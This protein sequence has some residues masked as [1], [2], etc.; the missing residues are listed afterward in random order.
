M[1]LPPASILA[2]L[3]VQNVGGVSRCE[4]SLEDGFTVFTGESGAGKSSI[5][6]AIE[7][8]AGKRAQ[9]SLI[10]A[11]EE[12]AAVEA[13]FSTSPNLRLPGLEESQQP[14][15]GSF[16]AKRALSR[17]GRGRAIL[18]GTQVPVALYSSSVGRLVHI[19]SQFAQLELL[20]TGRQL[21]MTD[22][23]G[24]E[25]LRESLEKLREVFGRARVKEREL[26]EIADRRA[27]IERRYAN[28]AEVVPLAKKVDL[29]EGLEA[30]L[31]AEAAD[32]SRRLA[33]SA[34]AGQ[35]LDRL[36]G[37]LSERGL[38]DEA[39]GLCKV[40]LE[41]VPPE[42]EEIC[43]S[44]FKEGLR[45]L[46]ALSDE[47]RRQT[48]KLPSPEALSR[49]IE[50]TERRLGSLR[51]LRRMAG[52]K[53]EGELADW[54]REAGEGLA[55]L[56]KSYDRLETFTR[57]ARELRREASRLA[58]EI[59]AGRRRAAEALEKRV[60]ALFED[61]A[62][63]GIGFAIR[64]S[65]LPKLRRDGA[66]EV[67]FELFTDKRSG[68][69]D[70]IA[71]G[72]E[73]SRLLLALQLSLPDEWL[74]PTLVFDEVE[75]GLGGRAA[76]LSGLKLR[77][78]SRG[79]QVILVTHEASIAALGDCHYVVR[80]QEGESRVFRAEGEERVREIARMLSGDPGLPEAQEHARRLLDGRQ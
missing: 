52:A 73:L 66:D 76:V 67:E 54:C 43:A 1:S 78:L 58:L 39:A 61:L 25:P 14:A 31:E 57:E 55:W 5:V 38:L 56:E 50:A 18:Q 21:A 41:C 64:F 27:D 26:R 8:A 3:A 72:G 16:F 24:G 7:L 79:C 48:A 59:R 74:P 63:D 42:A 62:M 13:V 53:S 33:A 22:S 17:G 32:L 4:I 10:R 28:A 80:K 46:E 75:A 77:E 60:N 70:K 12:E 34:R 71:S 47:V 68:R 35:A 15:E 37:G 45:N 65:E 2:R 11:G 29:R 6:R 19:Q 40:L 36:T 23:C 9:A 30:S 69:V 44:F 49:E 51:K 20:D